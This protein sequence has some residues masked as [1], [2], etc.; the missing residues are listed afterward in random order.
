MATQVATED[1]AEA[2][3]IG[4]HSIIEVDSV[5]AATAIL[6]THP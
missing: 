3:P 6:S 1:G 2:V 4:G 5:E